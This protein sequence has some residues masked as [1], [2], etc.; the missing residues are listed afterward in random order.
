MY[1]RFEAEN[2]FI[3]RVKA[4]DVLGSPA[5]A[6]LALENVFS[7]RVIQCDEFLNLSC[8]A[9]Q[10]MRGVRSTGS[11]LPGGGMPC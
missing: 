11:G 1:F 7:D 5:F 4:L 10:W 9:H 6:G 3:V 8:L 2:P